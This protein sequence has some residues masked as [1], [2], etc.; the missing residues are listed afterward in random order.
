MGPD[1]SIFVITHTAYT[2]VGNGF[3]FCHLIAKNVTVLKQVAHV[4]FSSSY[5]LCY[6]TRH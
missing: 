4:P 5:I 2:H 6:I 3:L 1:I